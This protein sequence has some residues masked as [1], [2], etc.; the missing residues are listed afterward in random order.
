MTKIKLFLLAGLVLPLLGSPGVVL[1][2]EGWCYANYKDNPRSPFGLIASFA[3]ELSARK[4][5]GQMTEQDF[6]WAYAEIGKANEA[7][8]RNEPK[9]GCLLLEELEFEFQLQPRPAPLDN[10]E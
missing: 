8:A 1:A 9:A 5:A 7:F 3:L 2:E 6:N 10:P 4:T